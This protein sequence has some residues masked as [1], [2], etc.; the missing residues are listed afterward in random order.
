MPSFPLTIAGLRDFCNREQERA[1]LASNMQQQRHTLLISPRRYGKTS[2]VMRTLAE[3]KLP[4]CAIDLFAVTDS[5]SVKEAFFD[6]VGYGLGKLLPK[7]NSLKQKLSLT[8][9]SM[10]PTIEL[11]AFGQKIVLHPQ[12][13]TTLAI[14][15]LLLG[16]DEYAAKQKQAMVIFLDEF[17]QLA[18]IK[19][20]QAIEGAIRSAMQHSKYVCY[21]FSGSRRHLLADMFED[22]NKPFYHSCEKMILQRISKESYQPFLQ[23]AAQNQWQQPI[24]SQSLNQILEYCQCHAYYVNLLCGKLWRQSTAPTLED[25]EKTWLDC[26]TSESRRVREEFTRLSPNQRAM[27]TVIA[28]TPSSEPTGKEIISHA[29]L[30]SSS[31][32]LALEYLFDNDWIYR[33]S[34]GV[35]YAIDP[36]IAAWLQQPN[37]GILTELMD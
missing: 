36:V 1:D 10:N 5:L 9:K 21:V 14:Q 24:D 27:L 35:I 16:L 6:G 12:Q 4:Y 17:Q 3:T 18:T 8:L 30:S 25:V 26:I 37:L 34:D 31:A 13:S 11:G 2:L 29:R 33:Q 23:Q 7:T 28:R 22:S 19:D 20:G 32:K 15:K